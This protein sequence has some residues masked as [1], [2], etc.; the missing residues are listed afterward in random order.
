MA[1]EFKVVSYVF[2]SVPVIVLNTAT[3]EQIAFLK[4]AIL[5]FDS[6]DIFYTQRQICDPGI[7]AISEDYV[8]INFYSDFPEAELY[9]EWL[10]SVY[11]QTLL[12]L[13][14]HPG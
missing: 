6:S 4:R 5:S 1:G 3:V 2:N 9:V 13:G 11:D 8:L 14:F 7:A 12:D 10:N